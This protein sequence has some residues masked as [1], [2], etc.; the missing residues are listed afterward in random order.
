[1]LILCACVMP[2]LEQ[3]RLSSLHVYVFSA[4]VYFQITQHMWTS[5]KITICSWVYALTCEHTQTYIPHKLNSS[6]SGKLPDSCACLYAYGSPEER[7][8]TICGVLLIGP[9]ENRPKL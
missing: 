7:E 9:K 4:N 2:A 5:I 8:W 3:M 1:M 6:C